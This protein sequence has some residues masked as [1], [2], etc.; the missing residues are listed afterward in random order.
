MI[1]YL[2]K[3][4]KRCL[5]AFLGTSVVVP[6]TDFELVSK[7]RCLMSTRYHVVVKVERQK[8]RVVFNRP[9]RFDRH[10]FVYRVRSEVVG[11]C[12]EWFRTAAT[13]EEIYPGVCWDILDTS[14]SKN[15]FLEKVMMS[16]NEIFLLR[17]IDTVTEK[18][19]VTRQ[20]K[21]K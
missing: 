18:A 12:P 11:E 1:K 9:Y 19:K 10:H 17:L 20:S 21:N 4:L 15:L 2:L 13:H 7:A 6:L 8:C 5:G 3:A 14:F 16:I